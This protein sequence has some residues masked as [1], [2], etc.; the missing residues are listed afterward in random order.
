[1]EQEVINGFTVFATGTV[2]NDERVLLAVRPDA[3][4]NS[5]FEYVTAR[6]K[7]P[8]ADA[9]VTSW[10]WG[11]YTHDFDEAVKDFKERYAAL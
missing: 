9:P 11:H 1:M 10:Y 2:G 5:G 6:S 7:V 3:Y 4:S 8:A